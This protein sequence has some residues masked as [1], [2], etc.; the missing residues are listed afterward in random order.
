MDVREAAERF[1]RNW[2]DG[3][4]R[5]DTTAI[6]TLYAEQPTDPAVITSSTA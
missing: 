1:A 2:Q 6:A 3:W 5:Q 4:A